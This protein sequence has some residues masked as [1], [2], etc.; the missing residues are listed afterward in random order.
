MH[1]T[2]ALGRLKQESLVS[3]V[4]MGYIT[5]GDYISRQKQKHTKKQDG[6]K[7]GS[8]KDIRTG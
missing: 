8:Y 4:I 6:W 1:V 3:E 5:L 7:V 2:P